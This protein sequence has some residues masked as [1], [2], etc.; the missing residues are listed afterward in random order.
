M[1][2]VRRIQSRGANIVVEAHGE[3]LFS[4][5][6]PVGI[7][8]NRFSNKLT[9]NAAKAAPSNK[10]PRWAHYG[11]PL[12]STMTSSTTYQPGN[13][14]VYAA[15]GSKAPHAY[16]VDQGTGIYGGKGPYLAKILPP[17]LPGSPSLYEATWRPDG[18]GHRRVSPV[19]I[20][21]QKGQHF[22]DKA[23]AKTFAYM[24]MRAFQVPGNAQ[25]TNAL[26][27]MPTG[28]ANFAGNTPADAGFKTQ[29]EEWREW[30]DDAWS[31]GEGLGRAAGL[32]S[33]SHQKFKRDIWEANEARLAEQG[34]GLGAL[35]AS[36][37]A[38]AQRKA[39]QE[40][41]IRAEKARK[42]KAKEERKAE[43]A[44]ELQEQKEKQ[45]ERELKA[46]NAQMERTAREFLARIKQAYPDAKFTQAPLADGV[47][48]YRVRYT[49][50]GETI[51]Q[52][53]A[54]GYKTD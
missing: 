31:R 46:G 19:M 50:D 54:W 36:Q 28:L 17:W 22:F 26:S 3:V 10:R 40:A 18:P 11:K 13:M 30:R 8:T 5:V 14:R 16:Y 38:A 15:V 23:L 37:E 32:T 20:R 6:G 42:K 25:I 43:E 27:S 4:A 2:L 48:L 33:K 45:A 41:E 12:K 53:W 51:T 29:L 47:V 24:R 39:E 34:K 1:V 49:V 9:A 44:K 52:Q 7:W 21:G 35:R